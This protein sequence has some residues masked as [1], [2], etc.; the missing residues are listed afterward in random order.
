MESWLSQ[1]L[2]PNF[3]MT[4]TLCQA[5]AFYDATGH[6]RV[7]GDA[8]QYAG[9]CDQFVRRL[10]KLTYGKTAFRRSKKLIPYAVVLEGDG[11]NKRYH[12]H[13]MLRRPDWVPPIKFED[14]CT[15]SWLASPWAMTDI[16]LEE[17]EGRWVGYCCKE[18]PEA[19]LSASF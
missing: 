17:I 4:T 8:I 3:A 13:W 11:L 14:M 10:S 19:L 1:A 16:K 5:I 6:G 12:L 7:S 15:S 18:G 9:A 2:R